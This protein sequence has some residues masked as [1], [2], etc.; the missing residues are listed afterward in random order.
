MTESPSWQT[1]CRASD[2][3]RPTFYRTGKIDYSIRKSPSLDAIAG[4]LNPVYTILRVFQN[5]ISISHLPRA[6]YTEWFYII[7]GV[8]MAFIFQTGRNK[9]KL[10]M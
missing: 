8:S 4:Q 7:V 1:D 2:K 3:K 5:F 6:G 10:F 9:I